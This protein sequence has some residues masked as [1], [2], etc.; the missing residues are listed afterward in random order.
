M[1]KIEKKQQFLYSGNE[2]LARGAWEAGLRVAAAY[3][4]TPSTEILENIA[5]YTEIDA[6][7]SVNEK[8]AYE[9]A[10]GA[11][12]GGARS[13]YA[14]KHVG[15]NVAM[16]PF[17]T[18]VYMG[19]NAG[20]VAV[21]CDDPGLHSSQNE[22][23]TRWVS[24]FGKAPLIEPADAAEAHWFIQEAFVLSER[25]DTPVLFRMTTRTAHAKQNVPVGERT[26]AQ[27]RPL[28]RD[29]A[30]YVMVPKN[31]YMRHIKVEERLV[32]LARFAETA[33]F[34]QVQKGPAKLGFITSGVSHAYVRDHYPDAAILK[35]G[36][37]YPLCEKKIRAFAKSVRELVV[38]EELDPFLETQLN[39]LKIKFRAKHPS[40]RIG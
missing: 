34:N 3:P 17:M 12:I 36:M 11:A 31:A 10:Y 29:M 6:Q 26:E 39:A 37:L 2:A 35:L 33:R 28:V 22:Q 25:F 13:L 15:L 20:F 27:T 4:G 14:S 7:W 21:V 40:Y 32:A 1:N 24:I 8:V 38:V 23:D 19:I 30:K 16:D 18:S 5:T 9:V